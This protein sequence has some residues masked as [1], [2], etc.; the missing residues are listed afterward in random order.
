LKTEQDEL[1]FKGPQIIIVASL[2]TILHKTIP[3]HDCG[4]G[5]TKGG[6]SAMMFMKVVAMLKGQEDAAT[7]FTT[8]IL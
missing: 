4:R 7:V 6:V 8:M 1:V 3:Q 2:Y 5:L